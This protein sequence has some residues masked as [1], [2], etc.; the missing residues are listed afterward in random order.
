MVTTTKRLTPE[1]LILFELNADDFEIL[2]GELKERKT[3]GGRHGRVGFG[4]GHL[5]ELHVLPKNLGRLYTSDTGFVISEEPLTVLRPDVAFVREER[6]LPG[7]E[8]RAF[9]PLVPDLVVEVLSPGDRT[10]EIGAKIERCRRAQVPLVWL[11]D[12]GSR[13]VQVYRP[14]GPALVLT[15]DDELDG[16]VVLPGFRVAVRDILR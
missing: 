4:V 2:D 8:D 13:T 3:V 12:P 16:G 11:V 1:D 6:I 9:M 7:M 15:E 10:V 5:L 14:D